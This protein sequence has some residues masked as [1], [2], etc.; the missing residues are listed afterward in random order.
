M[1]RLRQPFF[2]SLLLVSA[3]TAVFCGVRAVY[4]QTS[5][6]DVPP[7]L[8]VGITDLT[9]LNKFYS[10]QVVGSNALNAD[11]PAVGVKGV[12]T[13]SSNQTFT[14]ECCN[15]LEKGN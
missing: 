4:A 14:I 3:L 11:V 6:D 1:T 2:K 9:T 12:G 15:K 13:L 10:C 7:I 5:P 8:P